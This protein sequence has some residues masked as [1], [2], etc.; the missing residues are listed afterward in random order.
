VLPKLSKMREN[1]SITFA[2]TQVKSFDVRWMLVPGNTQVPSGQFQ[3][4][5]YSSSFR[6]TICKYHGK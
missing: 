5:P 2:L 1:E 4:L 6:E 3:L